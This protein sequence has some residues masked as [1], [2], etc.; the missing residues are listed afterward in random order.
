[1][2]LR[3][4]KAWRALTPENVREVPGYLGVYQVA[5]ATGA[6]QH[7]GFAGARTLFGLRSALEE[8][9]TLRPEGSLFRFEVN[10]QYRSRFRELLMVHLADHGEL[11]ALN[12][13]SAPVNLGRLH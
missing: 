8:E 12:R 1:M 2:E 6:V 7:I 13:D 3:I 11:P 4:S 10:M 9:M 5:D